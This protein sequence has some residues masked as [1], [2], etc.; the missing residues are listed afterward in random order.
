MH[1][2]LEEICGT[3]PV[4]MGRWLE[5]SKAFGGFVERRL[6]KG[7]LMQSSTLGGFLM[8]YSLAGMRRFR[9]STLRHQIES[10]GLEQWLDLIARLC[11]HLGWTLRLQPCEARGTRATLDFSASRPA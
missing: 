3:L 9:R 5:G 10:A 4:R 8:L 11:E 1:P 7:R 2:R 6:G